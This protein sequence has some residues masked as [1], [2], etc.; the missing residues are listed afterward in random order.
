LV[1]YKREREGMGW[2]LK[3]KLKGKKCLFILLL[4]LVGLYLVDSVKSVLALQDQDRNS[5]E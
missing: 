5:T 1:N 4:F 3:Q 2:R